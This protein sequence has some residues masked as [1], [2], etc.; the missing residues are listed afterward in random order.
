MYNMCR[1]YQ[2]NYFQV[3]THLQIGRSNLLTIISLVFSYLFKNYL[4]TCLI[5]DI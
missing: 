2:Y 4:Q 5:R 1:Q 3:N